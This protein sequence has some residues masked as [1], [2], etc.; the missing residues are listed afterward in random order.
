MGKEH[1][2]MEKVILG[3]IEKHLR[4]NT[5]PDY[6]QNWFMR[7]KSCLIKLISFYDNVTHLVG[8]GKPVDVVDLDFSKTFDTASENILLDKMSITYVDKSIIHYVSIG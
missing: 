1:K 3:V 2:I 7:G 5:V 4:D 6:S 8:Q